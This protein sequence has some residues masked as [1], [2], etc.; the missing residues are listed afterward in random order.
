VMNSNMVGV[1]GQAEHWA[2]NIRSNI[3]RV[4]G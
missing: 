1:N 2:P 3:R 4:G